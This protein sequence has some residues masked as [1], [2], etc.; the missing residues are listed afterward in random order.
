MPLLTRAEYESTFSPPMLDVTQS[1][2]EIVDLWNYAAEVVDTNYP[3]SA[4]WEWKVM[5]IYESRDGRTQH[6]NI[7]VPRNN[8]YLSVVVD[9][10]SRRILGHYLLNLEAEHPEW[11]SSSQH[12][13]RISECSKH[14]HSTTSCT[15]CGYTP[16]GHSDA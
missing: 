10:P 13:P 5:F 1:A 15:N 14:M 8:T 12:E 2:D 16:T 6:L 11:K 3:D 4:D 7:P 9:K